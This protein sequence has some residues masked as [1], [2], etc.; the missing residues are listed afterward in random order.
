[1][2]VRSASNASTWPTGADGGVPTAAR[3]NG[4]DQV[5]TEGGD[6]GGGTTRRDRTELMPPSPSSSVM[7]T[8]YVPGAAK[9]CIATGLVPLTVVPSPKSKVNVCRS[10]PGSG[11]V[12]M[13]LKTKVFVVPVGCVG[14][15]R[16]VASTGATLSMKS[17]LAVLSARTSVPSG[18][19][20]KR[21][22]VTATGE[23]G[24]LSSA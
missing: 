15:G 13:A 10:A 1:M 24:G 20:K 23:P 9:V 17:V 16:A 21:S 22:A 2:A 19:L 14:I 6:P 8:R 3:W 11:V 12:T 4:D 5:T 7:R 18:N